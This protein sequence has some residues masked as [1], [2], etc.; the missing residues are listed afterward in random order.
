MVNDT[1]WE[2]ILKGL[3]GT[4]MACFLVI[5]VLVSCSVVIRLGRVLF[6]QMIVVFILISCVD[7]T[8]AEMGIFGQSCSQGPA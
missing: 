4:K 2:G 6:V 8:F 3:W 5:P 1:M 7:I